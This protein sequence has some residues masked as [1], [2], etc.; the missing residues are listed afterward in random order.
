MIG[1]G[2]DAVQGHVQRVGHG[3]R[4]VCVLG[5]DV[6]AL[7]RRQQTGSGL[8]RVDVDGE[9]PRDHAGVSRFRR[10]V[11]AICRARQPYA[12]L[13]QSGRPFSRRLTARSAS[14]LA[15]RPASACR[16][17]Q[18]F[19]PRARAISTFARPSLK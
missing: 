7:Q 2:V 10:A 15:S 18:V 9:G 14:R 1:E 6:S 17:S 3:L 8:V 16:L 4:V 13:N 19:L 11:D 5:E 12:P